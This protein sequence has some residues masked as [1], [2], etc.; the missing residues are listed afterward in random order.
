[1]LRIQP[2]R[3]RHGS[4]RVI[5]F[6][7]ATLGFAALGWSQGSSTISLNNGVRLS[8]N[9]IL[10]APTESAQ[11]EITMFRASGDSFYRVF[12]DQNNQAIF[13]YELEVSRGSGEDE[14]SL[15][16]K[17]AEDA[18]AG[19]FPAA[20]GGKPVPTLSTAQEFLLPAGGMAEIGLFALEG[21][22]LRVVDVARVALVDPAVAEV[23]SPT[24]EASTLFRF[25]GLQV[26]IDGTPIKPQFGGTVVGRYAMFYI[27]GRGAYFFSTDAAPPGNFIKAGSVEHNRMRFTLDNEVFDCVADAPILTRPDV[28]EIWVYHDPTYKPGGNW[29]TLSRNPEQVAFEHPFAAAADSLQWWLP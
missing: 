19:R 7:I 14:F 21:Q 28:G 16:A 22:G 4:L 26:S 5:G 25:S 29:T 10:G 6:A 9:A 12:R 2:C 18:F 20:D 8:I 3:C 23:V 1:M 11:L 17:P 27:P 24:D 13:A 15:T